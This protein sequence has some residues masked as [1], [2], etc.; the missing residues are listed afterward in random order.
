MM[1]PN[2]F[3][4]IRNE[5]FKCSNKIIVIS[6]IMHIQCRYI[7]KHARATLSAGG[8]ETKYGSMVAVPYYIPYR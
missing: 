1:R 3:A 4:P 7:H 8:E 6:N 5:Y 2:S